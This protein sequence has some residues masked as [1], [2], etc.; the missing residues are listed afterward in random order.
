MIR[1]TPCQQ[2]SCAER[3]H[4]HP[5]LR[6]IRPEQRKK[7]RRQRR[8][9]QAA[10]S[11]RPTDGIRAEHAEQG[12]RNAHEKRRVRSRSGQRQENMSRRLCQRVARGA[13][14]RDGSCEEA[15]GKDR[16]AD[17]AKQRKHS[18]EPAPRKSKRRTLPDQRR[19][20]CGGPEPAVICP[21]P[22]GSLR[23]CQK[24][25]IEQRRAERAHRQCGRF[26]LRIASDNGER[27]GMLFFHARSP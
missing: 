10:D 22:G 11:R 1:C 6:G 16:R 21:D 23:Q 14:D 15:S 12:S 5:D 17:E 2:Q 4:R 18:T 3:T 20:A 7:R 13:A 26:F 24:P 19:S 8:Q 25:C 27:S 9:Q